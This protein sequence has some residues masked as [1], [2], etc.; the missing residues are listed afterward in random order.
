MFHV[1]NLNPGAGPANANNWYEN[2]D[3]YF[4]TRRLGDAYDA[5]TLLLTNEDMAWEV[6]R[7]VGTAFLVVRCSPFDTSEYSNFADVYDE[8]QADGSFAEPADMALSV[9]AA[10][11][12]SANMPR[13]NMS[14]THLSAPQLRFAQLSVDSR[15][16]DVMLR[17]LSA[18]DYRVQLIGAPEPTQMPP[19]RAP[20]A[21]LAAHH[22]LQAARLASV[23]ATAAAAAAVGE[24]APT[25]MA[26]CTSRP[27]YHR[28]L[29]ATLRGQ[30]RLFRV[31]PHK[32]KV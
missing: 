1:T 19:V 12:A 10:A 31:Q 5:A 27:T 30:F 4:R 3:Q 32:T 28:L 7:E 16:A 8:M 15:H 14:P 22:L 18:T 24:N 6:G 2:E 13:V 23:N 21:I 29:F 17:A 26:L 25:Y 9:A 11:A 20:T